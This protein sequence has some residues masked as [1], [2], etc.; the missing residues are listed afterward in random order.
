MV[1]DPIIGHSH[2]RLSGYCAKIG[3]TSFEGSFPIFIPTGMHISCPAAPLIFV[4]QD[5]VIVGLGEGRK[6]TNQQ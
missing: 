3:I 2:D 1:C 6:A 4:H 5:G